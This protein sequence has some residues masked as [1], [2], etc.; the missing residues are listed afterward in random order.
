MRKEFKVG[1]ETDRKL[2]IALENIRIKHIDIDKLLEDELTEQIAC[3][4]FA[5]GE[6]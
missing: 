5:Y 3:L 2:E 1:L 6:N 4:I